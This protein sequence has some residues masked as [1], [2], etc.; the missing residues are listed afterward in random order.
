MEVSLTTS[1]FNLHVITALLHQK[2]VPPL[3][4]WCVIREFSITTNVKLEWT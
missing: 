4:F 1:K 2:A 3:D